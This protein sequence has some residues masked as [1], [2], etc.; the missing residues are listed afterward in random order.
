MKARAFSIMSLLL[1]T[2]AMATTHCD[3]DNPIIN[4]YCPPEWGE[5]ETNDDCNPGVE[6]EDGCCGGE[7]EC[8]EDK[9][10]TNGEMCCVDKEY[11]C[12][13]QDECDECVECSRDS[14]CEH[15]GVCMMCENRCCVSFAC[16][17]DADCPPVDDLP[18]YCGDFDDEVGCR[19][20]EYVRCEIDADCEDPT[21]PLYVECTP[22][23][24]AKCLNG[25]CECRP[26]CGGSCPDGQ[27]CCRRT[28]TCDPIPTPCYGVECP[29]CEEVNPDPGGTLNEDTCQFEGSDCSC[30]PLPPLDDAFGGQHS[31][32]ALGGNGIPVLS[33]YYG[34]PYGDLLFGIASSADT[35]ATVQ[36]MIVDGVP[37]AEC[38]G[39]ADG[40][41]GGIEEPGDDVGWD[42]DIVVDS[43]GKPH[44]S[45]YDRT[46]GDL[47]YAVRQLDGSWNIQVI[48]SAGTTGRFTSIVLDTAERPII[49]Y[50][51]TRDNMMSRVKVARA[52]KSN[53]MTPVD[54]DLIVVDEAPVPCLPGDCD[55]ATEACLADTGTCETLDDPVNCEDA[56]GNQC[57]DGEVC[58]AAN[59]EAVMQESSLEVLPPGVG[60]FTNLA[61]Y[62]DNSPAVGYYDNTR[63]NLKYSWYNPGGGT[64]STP[65]ILAGEDGSGNDLGDLGSDVSM[66]ITVPD[67]TVHISFQDADL[68]DLYYLTFP[69]KDTGS[70]VMELID[71]GARDAN[72]DPT[73][74]ASAVGDLHWVGNFSTI[75]VDPLGYPRVVYQDG[76]SLDM[77]YAMRNAAGVWTVEIIARK[78]AAELF[79]GAW[80]FFTDQVMNQ[81]GDLAI[82]SNFKHNLRTDPWT[83]GIDIRTK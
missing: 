23:E 75:L 32:I 16:E 27:Y 13:T 57:P 22:P 43:L 9:H 67:E 33:G 30:L 41:R 48:D 5:C 52:N 37:D 74:Q 10:C 76:T 64:F 29:D 71:I 1:L 65:V 36:W 54:W 17:S 47:K 69:G 26:P 28:Q 59:C 8:L 77:L 25:M 20:C 72:G 2:L 4:K 6:C 56:D 15:L 55:A 66:H 51:T 34:Q 35:G 18:R 68:G 45:Y 40:P 82:I 49:S 50:M 3:C 31:A 11:Q 73:D 12:M 62:A 42:T 60:L 79:D 19:R 39:A 24:K 80:G 44:I 7:V 83:S 46:N 78:L 61:L 14:Q 21:F 58:I 70:A 81:P 53:P 63:G 38:V